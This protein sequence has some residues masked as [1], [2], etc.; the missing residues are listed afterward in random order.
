MM[1]ILGVSGTED[2]KVFWKDFTSTPVVEYTV[3]YEKNLADGR[4]LLL[5]DAHVALKENDELWIQNASGTSTV[6]YI[7]TIELRPAEAI[8]FHG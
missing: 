5:T 7:A 1:Y 2:V 6:T 4:S 8:Q 3:V